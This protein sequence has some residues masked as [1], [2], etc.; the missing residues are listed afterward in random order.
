MRGEQIT[1][2][3]RAESGRRRAEGGGRIAIHHPRSTIHH[4]PFASPSALRPPPSAF[5]LV[6]L[7]VV[8]A[9]IGVLMG[10][11]LPAVQNAR[12]AARRA[13][14]TNNQ[15]QIGKAI[16]QYESTKRHLPGYVNLVWNQAL[17]PTNV[18]LSW[19]PV[20][21]PYIGRIDLW[22]GSGGTISWRGGNGVRTQVSEFICPDDMDSS[23]ADRLTYVVNVGVYNDATTTTIPLQ[24]GVVRPMPVDPSTGQPYVQ[25][26]G[27]FRD[28]YSH[29]VGS[30]TLL[31]PNVISLSDVRSPARTIMF[32]EKQDYNDAV[33]LREWPGFRT[34]GGANL[35]LTDTST[36]T[37]TNIFQWFGFTWPNCQ[38]PPLVPQP[39]PADLAVMVGTSTTPGT[40]IGVQQY[41][42]S[43]PAASTYCPLPRLHPGVVLMTFCDGHVDAVADDAQCSAYLATP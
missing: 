41:P 28:Y 30:T 34:T 42:L 27:V 26:Q 38:Q 6:E 5:T 37:T 29:N 40:Q 13:T 22:E 17:T 31:Y 24:P 23:T 14:C 43:S 12:E 9:I 21:F 20:L 33:M 3:R 39:T 25:L 10:L 7:L 36:T 8:I 2:G 16:I 35:N 32:A 15:M 11:L 4:S 1:Q 18:Q 19:V